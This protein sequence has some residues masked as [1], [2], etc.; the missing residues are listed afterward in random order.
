MPDEGACYDTGITSQ[1]I[2][3]GHKWRLS[4]GLLC[5][6]PHMRGPHKPGRAGGGETGLAG[7]P[8]IIR[9]A[10]PCDHGAALKAI[11]A[12]GVVHH[13]PPSRSGALGLGFSRPAARPTRTGPPLRG[14]LPLLGAFTPRVKEQLAVRQQ[15]GDFAGQLRQAMPHR[16]RGTP[17]ARPMHPPPRV[18]VTLPS[19]QPDRSASHSRRGHV[20]RRGRGRG[21]FIP[22]PA[23]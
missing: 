11:H 20:G 1:R 9:F 8:S 12:G 23:A 13:S 16:P 6:S 19:P 18:T 3:G 14:P 5:V 10:P 15:A 7:G 2:R 22:R 4:P 21:R 17:Q